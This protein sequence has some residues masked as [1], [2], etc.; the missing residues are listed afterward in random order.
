MAIKPTALNHEIFNNTME[1][2]AVILYHRGRIGESFQPSA[3]PFS[4]ASSIV[5]LPW[6]VSIST[7]GFPGIG[8]SGPVASAAPGSS[9]AINMA[10]NANVGRCREFMS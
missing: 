2:R 6:L 4:D 10:R 9:I 1:Y 5:I 3:G 8:C 7:F